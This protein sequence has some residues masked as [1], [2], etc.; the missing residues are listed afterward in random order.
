MSETTTAAPPPV[1]AATDS[2]KTNLDAPTDQLKGAEG[3]TEGSLLDK[4]ADGTKSGDPS[5]DGSLLDGAKPDKPES[6]PQKPSVPESYADPK[7][8]E[9]LTLIPELKQK[10]DVAAKEAG[11][12]QDQYQKFVDVQTAYTEA[13]MKQ[14]ESAFNR[15]IQ[16]WKDETKKHLGAEPDKALS[17][18]ARAIDRIFTD[19]AENKS[20]RDMMAQSGLGNWKL[21]VKAFQ[22][23]GEQ[24]GEDKFV[25]GKPGDQGRK[26]IE[27]VL[28]DHP[29]S[30]PSA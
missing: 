1:A 22:F 18:A 14:V 30:K 16:E 13:Q 21:M 19:P 6:A 26:S 23:V 28:F 5:K 24:L 11:L 4:P 17:T 25:A 9:G 7:L 20:F 8:P 27:D 10:F 15:Q 29:T 2:A 3:K 12:S